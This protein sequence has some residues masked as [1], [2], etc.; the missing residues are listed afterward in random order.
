VRKAGLRS[1][2]EKVVTTWPEAKEYLESQNP[3]LSDAHPVIFKILE[4]SGSEGVH[5]VHSLKQ[6]EEIFSSEVG[7][8]SWFG[9]SIAKILIQEFLQGED[10][11]IDSVSPDGVHK[12]VNVWNEDLR[13]GNGIFNM[14]VG[15]KMMDPKD[16]KTKAIIDYVNKVLDVT[17]VQNGASDLEVK[18]LEEEGTPCLVD[19]N[20]RWTALMWNTG[21]E[22]EKASVGN[23][24][25]TATV[26]A[27]LDG[28]AFDK[29]PLVPSLKEYGAIVFINVH[30]DGILTDI[31]G[32]AAAKNMPSYFSSYNK[33]AFVGKPIESFPGTSN[34]AI[35]IL[36]AHREK[37]VLDSDYNR[38][39]ELENSDAFFD[40][41]PST[42]YT[43]LTALRSGNGGLPGHR[44]PAIAALAMLAAA[45]ILA[46]A[47]M[48]RRNVP[49]GT[50]YL[51]IE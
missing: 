13:P 38:I 41:T 12:V 25:I 39:I 43:S 11:V 44:L 48:S 42:G 33:R 16:Q 9:K 35:Y 8:E 20:A 19:L 36:I 31:P 29:M 17:G 10:Y 18:W 23:D 24:Q 34:C 2:K 30:Q 6:A 47:V 37:A 46:H 40:I 21:L 7:G 14:Y 5:R 51:T 28:D 1:V 50:E 32:L 22:I 49:D 45:A 27:Y 4:G 3:P 26:N 15:F